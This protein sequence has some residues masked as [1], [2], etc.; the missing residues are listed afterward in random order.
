MSI[1]NQAVAAFC[2]S[3]QYIIADGVEHARQDDP[4]RFATLPA[5]FDN[6]KAMRRLVVDYLSGGRI[7]IA[8]Q[9]V[10]TKGGEEKVVELFSTMVQGPTY[11]GAH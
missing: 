7:R 10:G 8:Q 4:H 6:G 11:E 3:A 9:F 1:L 5:E 2:E